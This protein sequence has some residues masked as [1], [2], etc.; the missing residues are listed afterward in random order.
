MDSSGSGIGLLQVS[1]SFGFPGRESGGDF[2][3]HWH[4]CVTGMRVMFLL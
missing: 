1:H 4:F 3:L 2:V